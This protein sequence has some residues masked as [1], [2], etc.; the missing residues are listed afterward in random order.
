MSLPLP[1]EPNFGPIVITAREVYDAVVR[2]S[3]KVDAIAIEI[4]GNTGTLHDHEKRLRVIERSRWP[5]PAVAVLISAAA[6]MIN[7]FS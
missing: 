1:P 7:L 3:A 2:V 6:V 4:A 5:L